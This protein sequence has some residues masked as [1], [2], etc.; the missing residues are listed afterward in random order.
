MKAIIGLGNP[1]LEYEN[2]RHN[3]G[4]IIVD[5]IKDIL[6]IS[7][8]NKK[9]DGLF[10]MKNEWILFKPCSFM[11]LSGIPVMKLL[12]FYKVSLNDI[13]VIHDDLDLPLGRIKVKKGG[14]S[15]GHNGIRS[16][17]KM[18]GVEYFR[19][20]IGIGK[21]A[22]NVSGYVL[23][24]FSSDEKIILQK[25]YDYC[26]KNYTQLLNNEYEKFVSNYYNMK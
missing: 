17:D 9:F 16:I 10:S 4:F 14:G 2:T 22:Y 5:L 25:L 3:I 15:G 11:N 8:E 20:R 26:K 18:L 13:L 1:G 24:K 21:P 7:Q 6:N 23:E 19:L 12:Q